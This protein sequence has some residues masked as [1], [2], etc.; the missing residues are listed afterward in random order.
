MIGIFFIDER[1][2]CDWKGVMFSVKLTH[3]MDEGQE[4]VKLSKH[5]GLSSELIYEAIQIIYDLPEINIGD[6]CCYCCL[7]PQPFYFDEYNN[8]L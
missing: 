6:F 3:L 7:F 4:T 8:V 1:C 5:S 2:E